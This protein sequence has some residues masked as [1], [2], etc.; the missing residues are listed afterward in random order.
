VEIKL[1]MGGNK[2]EPEWKKELC[3]DKKELCMDKK[4]F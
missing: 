1:S 4:E 2:V 3:M